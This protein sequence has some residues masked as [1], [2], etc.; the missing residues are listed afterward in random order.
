MKHVLSAAVLAAVMTTGASVGVAQAQTYD[1]QSVFGL[2]VPSIGPS[3]QLWADRV[4]KMTGGDVTIKVHG[5][6]EF[7]PPFEVFGAVSSGALQMGFDWI[8]YWAQQIPVANLVGSMPFG[9]TPDIALAWMFEGGG[10][11][12]IQ[13]AYDPL[14]VKVLP[15]HLVQQGNQ[16]G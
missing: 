2:N 10:L 6:G 15:C 4:S 12:I 1:L 5:A 9:P 8:G 7:V 13:K 14:N 11:E 16:H 3:P